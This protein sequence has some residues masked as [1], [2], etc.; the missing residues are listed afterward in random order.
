MPAIHALGFD[1]S[2][3]SLDA[4]IR[5]A[6]RDHTVWWTD[7]PGRGVPQYEIMAREIVSTARS[8]IGISVT[9]GRSELQTADSAK[10]TTEP[11]RLV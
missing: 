11:F 1:G 6:F 10:S 7:W 4:A 5:R 3:E 9:Q 2:D 8:Y